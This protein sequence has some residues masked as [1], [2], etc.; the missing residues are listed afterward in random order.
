MATL[1]CFWKVKCSQKSNE[2]HCFYRGKFQSQVS[3]ARVVLVLFEGH[4]H[5]WVQKTTGFTEG[6]RT[7]SVEHNVWL[8]FHRCGMFGTGC[9]SRKFNRNENV[10]V[11]R[12]FDQR[13]EVQETLPAAVFIQTRLLA[14]SILGHSMASDSSAVVPEVEE[15]ESCVG[16]PPYDQWTSM[17]GDGVSCYKCKVY[18]TN[19]WD[20]LH[21]HL[22]SRCLNT[23]E[24]A[25]LFNSY[26]H[27][28]AKK[29][30]RLKAQAKRVSRQPLASPPVVSESETQLSPPTGPV[31]LPDGVPQVPAGAP[32][33]LP[34]AGL[35]QQSDSAESTPGAL[36]GASSLTCTPP[37]TP[38]AVSG[39]FPSTDGPPSTPGALPG[40]SAQTESPWST[41]GARP[42]STPGALPRVPVTEEPSAR[43]AIV[44]P[45]PA[46]T[47]DPLQS[48]HRR[49]PMSP[50]PRTARAG[51]RH[52]HVTCDLNENV[53]VLSVVFNFADGR[54]V[55]SM[56][57]GR[58]RCHA[59]QVWVRCTRERI[60]ANTDAA[61][62]ATAR[63]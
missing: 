21:H 5:T 28:Q 12:V 13:D 16:P 35:Q 7:A 58:D 17:E 15:E 14:F 8:C 38:G 43:D 60:S 62:L 57:V 50:W 10:D 9:L 1:V 44:M 29:E 11:S 39:I 36:P 20:K 41:P 31:T 55:L 2:N 22:R 48:Q 51:H 3:I 27:V 23:K 56:S 54:V 61:L 63:Q 30:L 33:V 37:T 25:L 42:W 45:P 34:A 53:D 59:P 4:V 40:A 24:K 19:S 47:S 18:R 32:D 52:R 46:T 26:V 49:H 6:M